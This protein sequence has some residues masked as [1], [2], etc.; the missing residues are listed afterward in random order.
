LQLQQEHVLLLEARM[1]D[2]FGKGEVSIRDLLHS[3]LR[4]RPDRIIIGE[5]RGGEALDLLQA[6]NTGHGGSMGTIH[7]NSP[8]DALSRL[9]T[10]ALYA[11]VDLPLRVIR[12][13]V[14]A[15]IDLVVQTARYTD[16]SRKIS[17]ISEVLPLDAQGNYQTAEIFYFQREGLDQR[18]QIVGRHQATGRRP[19]FMEEAAQSGFT[20]PE[21]LFQA[22]KD[23]MLTA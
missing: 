13:Q 15:A 14:A 18:Q 11:G 12:A 9:E 3:T 21:H 5:I 16:G 4:L 7:A 22:G 1:A 20:L 19:G 2:R 8:A 17:H 6:M 23:E 10:L